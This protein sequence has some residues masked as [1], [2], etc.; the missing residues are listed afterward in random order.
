MDA[1]GQVII[2]TH[3]PYIA[4]LAELHEIR[5]LSKQENSVCVYQL[6]D[7]FD[8]DDLRKLRREV[9][10]SRG[11]LLFSKAIVLSEGETEE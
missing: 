8:G 3:S 6:R 4:G 10:H 7:K 11:E 9:V 1:P 5:F 2:S